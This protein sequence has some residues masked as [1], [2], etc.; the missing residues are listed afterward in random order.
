MV[1]LYYLSQNPAFA[2]SVKPLM[3]KIKDS[4]QMLNFLNDLSKFATA[5]GGFSGNF[6]TQQNKDFA[7]KQREAE[8]ADKDG[9]ASKG[10]SEKTGSSYHEQDFSDKENF[11]NEAENKKGPQS[12]T[13]GIADEFIQNIL[14]SYLKKN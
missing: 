2:E 10:E 4:E 5:F 12:P 7:G 14:E 13:T 1:L 6:A 11:S 8:H 9:Y 3:G